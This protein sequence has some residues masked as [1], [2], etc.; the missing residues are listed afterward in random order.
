MISVI[1]PVFKVEKFLSKCIESILNQTY[2][3]IEVILVDDGS[4]DKCGEICDLYAQRDK[5]VKVIHKENGGQASAR[6]AGL[7][8]ATGDYISFIDSDDW[9]D[10]DMY[11]ELLRVAKSTDADIVGG[12]VSSF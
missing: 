6:N 12:G 2:T 1:V 8:I 9:I 7:E 11:E 3:D 10:K 4:P 5:R